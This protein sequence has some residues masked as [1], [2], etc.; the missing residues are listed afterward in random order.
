MEEFAAHNNI[1]DC[2]IAIQDKVYDVTGFIDQHTGGV[3]K[4]VSGCGKE[5]TGVFAKI[6]SNK[7]WDL[8][9]RFQIGSLE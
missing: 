4:I 2:Y 7:S 6:H 1:D 5:M 8:L 9:K 3:D